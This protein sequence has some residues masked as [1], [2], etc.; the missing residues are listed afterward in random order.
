M[1][2]REI[3]AL[4]WQRDQRAIAETA[5]KY[6][7]YCGAIAANIL[8]SPEDVEESLNDT[9][10]HA[11]NS[12][13]PHR[14]KV[15]SSFLG[16]LTRYICLKRWRE[17]HSQKRGGGQ[18]ALVL[19]ELAGCISGGE[20][21]ERALQAK[22]LAGILNTFLAALPRTE[23]DVFLR[24]YWYLDPISAISQRFG[25]SQ[26]KVKTMLWRTRGK[27]RTQLEKEGVFD[28]S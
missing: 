22:E 27:L 5:A 23:R 17:S 10:M 21:P 20:S 18:V 4:Y 7:R 3:V 25:F 14:P 8:S 24:R 28:E 15:L 12:M 2:D 6:G 19:D 13:P 26:S 16:K 9:W 11:W 1:E